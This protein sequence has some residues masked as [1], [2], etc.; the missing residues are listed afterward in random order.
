MYPEAFTTFHDT[1]FDCA[2][3]PRV[4]D[5]VIVLS[6][7][8]ALCPV[9]ELKPPDALPEVPSIVAVAVTPEESE[10]PHDS[11]AIPTVRVTVAVLP[12]VDTD[13]LP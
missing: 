11:D 1:D 4:K 2:E 5:F 7:L 13:Q 3:C 6:D 10:K 9:P 12:L 8:L